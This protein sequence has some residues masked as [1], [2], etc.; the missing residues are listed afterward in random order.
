M[1]AQGTFVTRVMAVDGDSIEKERLYYQITD[2]NHD[3]AFSIEQQYSGRIF[4]LSLYVLCVSISFLS[5]FLCVCL[6]L[7]RLGSST[8][9]TVCLPVRLFILFLGLE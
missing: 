4:M 3:G 2:G 1:V 5:L 9:E 7:Y 8:I 6:S